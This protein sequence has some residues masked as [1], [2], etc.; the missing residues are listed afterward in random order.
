MLKRLEEINFKL[1]FT[2][3]I[4]LHL[5]LW[6]VL[7][8]LIRPTVMH[9]VVEGIAWGWQ[10]QLGYSKHPPLA[11]WL[12]ALFVNIFHSITWPVYLLAQLAIVISFWAIWRLAL[13]ITTPLYALISVFSLEGIIYYNRAAAKFTP[14]TIQT[15][16]W[17]LL[18]LLFY[19][20]IKEGKLW[21]WLLLGA[22]AGITLWG[23]YQAPVFF[24]AMFVVLIITQ[25]GRAHLKKL[26]PYLTGL[27]TAVV[28][29]PHLIWAYHYHF[30]ELNYALNSTT[31]NLH[32]TLHDSLLKR[33]LGFAIFF[34]LNQLGAVAGLLIMFIPFYFGPR[35]KITVATFERRFLFWMALGPLLLSLLYSSLTGSDLIHRW[36]I[37]YFS[38]LGLWLLITL[39]P[40]INWRQFKCFIGLFLFIALCTAAGR[41]LWLGYI[42]PYWAHNVKADA[43]YPARPIV[44]KV[45]AIWH[46]HYHTRLRYIAG[47]HYL[48]AYITVYSKDR[49]NPLMG[50]SEK[51][52]EWINLTKFKQAGGMLAWKTSCTNSNALP[53]QARSLFP[54]AKLLPKQQ[55][56]KLSNAVRKPLCI[57]MAIVPPEKNAKPV[58]N[59]I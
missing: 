14:D 59:Q 32:H 45:T 17:A 26:G 8:S 54:N 41:Y 29:I 49:P 46:E 43:Y 37:P 55:F 42:G 39:R 7:P 22:L 3:F 24:L 28:F 21:Q 5:V 35:T 31:G 47:N 50:W 44:N 25:E 9:D 30:P 1:W 52:S 20:T 10:W 48:T 53:I 51:Q 18:M 16:L 6:T 2:L 34:L 38:A 19:I 58:G 57:G 13:R 12:C 4:S 33:H 27:V 56:Y 15:P 40:Q 36:A 23:K 11:A